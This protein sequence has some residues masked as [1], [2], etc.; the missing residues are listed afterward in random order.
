MYILNTNMCLI[1][2]NVFP[3]KKDDHNHPD[4]EP[5]ILP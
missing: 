1:V 4:L 2:L 5:T 3:E